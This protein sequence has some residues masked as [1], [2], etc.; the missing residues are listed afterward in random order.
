MFF[1]GL[2]KYW[3]M[4]FMQKGK[5]YRFYVRKVID[6]QYIYYYKLKNFICIVFFR[7]FNK[8]FKSTLQTRMVR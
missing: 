3:G 1:G 8:Y 7:K 6:N 5:N 2:E 4:L